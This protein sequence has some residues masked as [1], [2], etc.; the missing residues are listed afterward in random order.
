MRPADGDASLISAIL[1][2]SQSFSVAG[3]SRYKRRE[4]LTGRGLI[5]AERGAEGDF[6]EA[7]GEP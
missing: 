2:F 4:A 1:L 7:L 3:F 6:W 5:L